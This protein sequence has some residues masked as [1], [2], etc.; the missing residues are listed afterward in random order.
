MREKRNNL[1][2][3]LTDLL[4]PV[5]PEKGHAQSGSAHD[6]V[7]AHH[8][9]LLFLEFMRDLS[10]HLARGLARKPPK[11]QRLEGSEPVSE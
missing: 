4:R 9:V 2:R 5:W 11:R 7:H 8:V 6:R 3:Q 10:I 1:R